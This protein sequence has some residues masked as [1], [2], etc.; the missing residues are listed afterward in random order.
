MRAAIARPRSLVPVLAVAIGT[1][2][3]RDVGAWSFAVPVAGA[4]AVLFAQSRARGHSRR[5]T[6]L[7]VTGVGVVA[8]AAVRIA[9]PG[10]PVHS[11][12]LA[13]VATIAAAVAEE[14]VFRRGMY[15]ALERWGPPAA[16][17]GCAAVFGL[18]H[19]PM[20]GWDVVP[21]DVGAGLLFGW[22][23]WASDTW[24]SPAATHAFANVVG[25]T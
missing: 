3:V 24:T 5:I 6:W 2:A 25:T 1:L 9:L 12:M 11:T 7:A 20:Y 8:V 23:R 4:A 16:I 22:Q 18:V 21:I 13:L 14:I 10:A 17:V 15:G 19:A